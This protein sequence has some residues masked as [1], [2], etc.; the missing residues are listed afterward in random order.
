MLIGPWHYH[1]Q[2][3]FLLPVGFHGYL[4]FVCMALLGSNKRLNLSRVYWP[5]V[6]PS[7]R[8]AQLTGCTHV[9]LGSLQFSF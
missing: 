9:L 8:H 4:T 3:L 5:F 7:L 6:S 2:L 1:L